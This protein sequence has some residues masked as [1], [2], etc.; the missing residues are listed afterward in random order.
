[1]DPRVEE[2]LDNFENILR[3]FEDKWVD[4]DQISEQQ[5]SIL[6]QALGSIIVNHTIAKWWSDDMRERIDRLKQNKKR[7]DIDFKFETAFKS[8]DDSIIQ[9]ATDWWNY[10]GMGR[11]WNLPIDL[12]KQIRV[13]GTPSGDNWLWQK[14]QQTYT[15]FSTG[16]RI[17]GTIKP[18]EPSIYDP[19][20]LIPKLI[21]RNPFN[22]VPPAK[23][24]GDTFVFNKSQK[25]IE[26]K[27][28]TPEL[29]ENF[30]NFKQEKPHEIQDKVTDEQL[31]STTEFAQYFFLCG[32]RSDGKSLCGRKHN[33][34]SPDITQVR[35]SSED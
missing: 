29:I 10:P 9:D 27:N 21:Y 2:K 19:L 7:T 31:C 26:I 1:M 22:D 33:G 28:A 11:L 35:L 12:K 5:I 25:R 3:G 8:S 18:D 15:D 6:Y 30:K 17:L 24:F 13:T 20:K 14:Y 23:T 4:G 32:G 16:K 34:F